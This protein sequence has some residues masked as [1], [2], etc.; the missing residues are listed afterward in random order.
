MKRKC[1]KEYL[2][3]VEGETEKLYLEKLQQ[4]IN[5]RNKNHVIFRIKVET[6]PSRYVKNLTTLK[7]QSKLYHICDIED[8][9]EENTLRL[10]KLMKDLQDAPKIKGANYVL[11]YSNITFELWIILHKSDCNTKCNKCSRYLTKI[12]EHFQEEFPSLKSYKEERNFKKCLDKLTL[13]DVRSAIQRAEQI[14]QNCESNLSHKEVHCGFSYYLDN[15]SL[16]IHL[17]IKQILNDADVL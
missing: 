17:I 11:G 1:K 7:K 8:P 16:S 3:S 14:Q 15:P 9:S 12:N 6:T 4:L 13:E 2:F 10:R 5:N